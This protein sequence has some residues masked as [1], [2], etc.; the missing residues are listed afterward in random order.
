[1]QPRDDARVLSFSES[2]D[3]EAETQPKKVIARKRCTY[4]AQTCTLCGYGRRHAGSGAITPHVDLHHGTV[5]VHRSLVSILLTLCSAILRGCLTY[6]FPSTV[7]HS[8]R[9]IVL[10]AAPRQA[11]GSTEYGYG[12]A[13]CWHGCTRLCTSGARTR[14]F[15]AHSFQGHPGAWRSCAESECMFTPKRGNLPVSTEWE[16]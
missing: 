7:T 6:A 16:I 5:T 1:M 12:V 8:M 10:S 14:R 3:I 4:P 9:L 11:S 2:L 15:R 13:S